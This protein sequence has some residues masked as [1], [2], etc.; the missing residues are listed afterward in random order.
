[1]ES[2]TSTSRPSRRGRVLLVGAADLSAV[3]RPVVG[4]DTVYDA[5]GELATAPTRDPIALVLVT[6]ELAQNGEARAAEALRQVDPSVPIALLAPPASGNGH[7][8]EVARSFETVLQLPR[9]LPRLC[10]MLGD[11]PPAMVGDR[12]PTAQPDEIPPVV[13]A[14]PA[15]STPPPLP[16]TSPPPPTPPTL[17]APPPL[18]PLPSDEPVLPVPNAESTGRP[19]R[20]WPLSDRAGSGA[21]TRDDEALGDVDL[22]DAVLHDPDGVSGR[23]LRLLAEQT[24]WSDVRLVPDA[25]AP[26]G[27]VAVGAGDERFGWLISTTATAGQLEPWA[28]WLER[29]L[30]LDHGYRRYRMLAYRDDLTG[31]WNRRFFNRFITETLERARV[32]RRPITVMV[33][34]IDNFKQYNDRFGHQAGDVVLIET[35]RLLNSV[36]RSGDHVCRIG[37][38]E[39]AVIFADVEGPRELGSTHPSSPEQ[40]AARFQSQICEMRFPKLGLEAPGTLSISA[41]LASFPWDGTTPEELLECADHRALRS[42]HNGKNAITLGPGAGGRTL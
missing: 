20:T 17:T 33:F 2:S 18:P 21:A 13:I 6:Y 29:W 22:I 37:G 14:E 15:R 31:A 4:V 19:S 26:D 23:A 16:T 38:D 3:A 39:F 24:G 12:E 27:A 36:I 10:A 5:L 34:D 11:P 40:I 9:E 7:V 42:K 32:K 8:A 41:G 35:V 28:R 1:M 25:S 30:E